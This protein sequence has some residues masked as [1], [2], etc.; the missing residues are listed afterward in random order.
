MKA[1]I[2]AYTAKG[3]IRPSTSPWGSPVLLVGKKG[4]GKRLCVDSLNKVTIKNKYP[5]PRIDDLFDI[6]SGAKI[7][8]RL[9]LQKGFH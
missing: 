6:I 5:L 9:D 2:D 7:F 8:S 3:F 4:G 1:E